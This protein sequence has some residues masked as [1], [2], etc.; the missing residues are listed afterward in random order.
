M[1]KVDLYYQNDNEVKEY[2][3]DIDNWFATVPGA[4][5]DLEYHKGDRRFA[6]D[7]DV[8][9]LTDWIQEFI[10][11]QS[12]YDENDADHKVALQRCVCYIGLGIDTQDRAKHHH[13]HRGAETPVYR[14]IHSI[15]KKEFR[16]EFN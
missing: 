16:N 8:R 12:G 9:L 13:S 2:A 7:S 6:Q 4:V 10:I 14:L 3:R 5:R 15:I 11:P 1:K